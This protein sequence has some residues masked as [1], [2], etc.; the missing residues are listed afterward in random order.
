MT[1][2]NSTFA[3]QLKH[4]AQSVDIVDSAVF[5]QVRD[6]VCRYVTNELKGRYFELLREES[7]DADGEKQLWLRTFWSSEE[8]L[9]AWP[10]RANDGTF[11]NSITTSAARGRP[12]W[13]VNPGGAPLGDGETARDLWS[14]IPDLPPFRP[15]STDPIRTAIVVPLRLQHSV[16]AYCIESPRYF[17]ATEVA[18]S[19]LRRL[20]EALAILYGLWEMNQAQLSYT[21][22]AIGDLRDLLD[23]SRF[24][25]L[26][27]P[28]MFIAFPA[29]GDETVKLVLKDVLRKFRDKLEFTDWS[30]MYESGNIGAQIGREI[31]ESRFGVC[32]LSQ[33]VDGDPGG[34]HR[35]HDNANVVFEAGMLHARMLASSDGEPGEPS[36]WI[37][38]RE[39]DSPEPP[40]DFAAERILVVPRSES[41]ELNESQLREQLTRRVEAL[42][43]E[44]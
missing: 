4:F 14:G 41:G 44:S 33:P 16:G 6:L 15:V 2:R 23:A 28:H 12:L 18:K 27:L 35:Y 11:T 40:F 17:E 8:K 42:L 13:L 9:H 39:S 36:G 7:P 1:A 24:P 19:E 20:G 32:Y 30:E 38:V 26:A 25:R 22:S 43:R 5:D 3:G 34:G 29:K 37:P 21:G 31:M 10:F